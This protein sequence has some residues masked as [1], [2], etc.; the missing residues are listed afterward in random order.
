MN[1]PA[2]SLSLPTRRTFLKTSAF[3]AAAVSLPRFSIGQPGPGANGKINVA[4]IGVGNRGWFAVSELMKNPAVHIVAICDVDQEMVN[5]T[6]A[7]AAELKKTAQLTCADLT[8]AQLFRD[9][10]EMFAKIADKIDAVTVS[11]PDH[12]HYPAAMLAI[13]H[14][15]HVYVEKPLTHTVGEARALRAAAKK[16]GIVS[17]MGNQ[18]RATEGIRLIKEWTDAGVLGDVREVHAWSP[19]FGEQHFK[20]P[21]ALPLTGEPVPPTMDW[22][23]WIGPAEM[24]PYSRLLAPQRWRGWW[25]FGNGMLG[26]WACHTLDAPFWALQ[27]GAPSSVEAQVSK[28]SDEIA[29]EWAEVTY[30]FPARGN[31]PPVTLKWF[32]GAAKRPKPPAMWEDAD[33]K[34]EIGLPNRGMLMLGERN[35]L[36]API[37]RPDSPR[38]L[39]NG[40]WEEFKKNRPPA[41]IPRVIG[42]PMK[43]WI[44]AIAKTGPMPGSNFEY[45]V[46]LSEMV[47]LGVIA[48]RTGK[49]LEWDAK[50]GR[51]TNDSSLNK[52]VEIKARKG[53]KV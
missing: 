50:T 29:P 26:D 20:R 1:L 47:L 41:M 30:K 15:K 18:G 38:L 27:L 40:V 42:G 22:D 28:V 9:Y 4:C 5:A 48:V 49:R 34:K 10:R 14:A 12:H 17:Q 31:R 8:E 45:S 6:Y 7:K 13:Q 37:G 11:T 33:P 16:Q 51:I 24:R 43:E 52:Y 25:N 36:F 3:A 19:E 21:D 53:W 44:D 23:L 32:E 46:A 2:S 39:P 35:T